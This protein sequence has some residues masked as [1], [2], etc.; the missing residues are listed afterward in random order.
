MDA[1]G[2]I[3]LFISIKLDSVPRSHNHVLILSQPD[4][5]RGC[6]F[7]DVAHHADLQ[8]LL[9]VILLVD[10]DRI[11]PQSLLRGYFPD[12]RKCIVQVAGN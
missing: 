1:L 4:E 8:A 11:R 9:D 10:A 12:L 5:N 2:G 6:S 3:I 7:V